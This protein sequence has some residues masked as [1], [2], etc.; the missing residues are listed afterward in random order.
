MTYTG[1]MEN[2]AEKEMGNDMES[3]VRQH[4]AGLGKEKPQVV[5]R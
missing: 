1:I 5:T 2:E 4:F 3:G